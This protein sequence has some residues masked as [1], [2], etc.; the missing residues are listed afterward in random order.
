MTGKWL[1]RHVHVTGG[2]SIH[3]NTPAA[4]S[5]YRLAAAGAAM[6]KAYGSAGSDGVLLWGLSELQNKAL[7]DFLY[8]GGGKYP[9]TATFDSCTCAVVR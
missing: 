8:E 7:S 3:I 9:T 5:G 4:S 1:L 6:R 2:Y